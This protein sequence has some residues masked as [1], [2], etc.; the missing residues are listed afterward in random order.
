MYEWVSKFLATSSVHLL[1]HR[2][3]TRTN[4]ERHPPQKSVPFLHGCL[5][6]FRHWSL[7]FALHLS[8]IRTIN[9]EAFID[10]ARQKYQQLWSNVHHYT[11]DTIASVL[12]N[13]VQNP[14]SKGNTC[15]YICH[16]STLK[17]DHKIWTLWLVAIFLTLI[18]TRTKTFFRSSSAFYGAWLFAGASTERESAYGCWVVASSKIEIADWISNFGNFELALLLCKRGESAQRVKLR[19]SKIKSNCCTCRTFTKLFVDYAF[20]FWHCPVLYCITCLI[21]NLTLKISNFAL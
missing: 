7:S 11:T 9:C 17:R 4:P 8:A 1:V 3:P 5:F 14:C 21:R 16:T 10:Y 6:W 13:F 15:L 19:R 12:K 20:A 2:G 18:N